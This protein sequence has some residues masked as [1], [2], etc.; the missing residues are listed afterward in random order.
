MGGKPFIALNI[1]GFPVKSLG[2]DILEKVLMGGYKKV[3]ESKALMVGGHSVDDEEPKYGLCVYG[4]VEKKNLWKV[5]GAREGDLLILTKPVGT[6]V[7]S[8]AIKA[9]MI[10]DPKGPEE[11][12]KWMSTLNNVPSI[13]DPEMHHSINACTDVTGFGLAGHVLD[14]LSKKDLDIVLG[15]ENVPV[16]PGSV[17]L[18]DSGL[19]PAGTYNNRIQY[20]DNVK[21]KENFDDCEVDMIFDAQTSGGLLLAVPREK[22]DL[23]TSKLIESG[24]S[25]S[26]IIGK[27]SKGNGRIELKNKI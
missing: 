27:F 10:E 6:G 24:F 8:T 14:M 5:T 4:E 3:N 12:I 11:S 13:I 21:N 19:I 17:D 7:I 22:A 15:I 2:L 9:D 1:V 16:L 25:H 23:L 26:C 20:E 18:A